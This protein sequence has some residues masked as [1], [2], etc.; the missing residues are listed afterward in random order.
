MIADE[1]GYASVVMTEKYAKC[2]LS[3][4]H[5]VG[6]SEPVDCELSYDELSKNIYYLED[7]PDAIL[8]ITPY[9]KKDCGLVP[10][11]YGNNISDKIAET[12][13]YYFMLYFIKL[14]YG[15]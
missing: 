11:R 14:F 13:T 6:Y 9:Y 1:I 10:S 5:L 12:R 8:Y 4:L 7:Q 15:K 3:R 2:K